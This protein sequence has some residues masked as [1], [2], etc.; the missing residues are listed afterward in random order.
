V[1]KRIVVVDD[2]TDQL[3]L[4]RILLEDQ[5]YQ[6]SVRKEGSGAVQYICGQQPD[7][8]ILDLK[9]QDAQG[10]DVLRQLKAQRDAAD[11]A[12]IVYSAAVIDL[13]SVERLVA[14]D[15]T[16]YAGVS[17]LKKPFDLDALLDQVRAM[18]GA[19]EHA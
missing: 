11:I 8:V 13:E 12:V 1:S 6:V 5:G 16:R 14:Q 7:L 19:G 18:L 2:E 17:V 3:R 9:L 4:M 15:A 10:L